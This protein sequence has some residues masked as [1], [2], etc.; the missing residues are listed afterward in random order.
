MVL[1]RCV[2]PAKPTRLGRV[3]KVGPETSV[4]RSVRPAGEE[5][6]NSITIGPDGTAYAGVFNGIVAVRDSGRGTGA[7]G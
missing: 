5:I 3:G 2:R 4:I 7:V 1:R 6:Q